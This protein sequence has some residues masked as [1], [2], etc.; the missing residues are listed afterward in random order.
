MVQTR[1]NDKGLVYLWI[2]LITLVGDTA[3]NIRRALTLYI[4]TQRGD[5]YIHRWILQSAPI[6][7]SI[8]L[9]SPDNGIIDHPESIGVV[10]ISPRIGIWKSAK[11]TAGRSRYGK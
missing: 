3:F 10:S 2:P 5:F 4:D 9:F 6:N 11:Q 1:D 7:F 8:H